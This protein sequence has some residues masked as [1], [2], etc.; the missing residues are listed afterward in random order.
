MQIDELFSWQMLSNLVIINQQNVWSATIREWTSLPLHKL[1]LGLK[2]KPD[3]NDRLH[4]TPGES[5]FLFSLANL[6]LCK[7]NPF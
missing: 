3:Y 1:T 2:N 7:H 4:C 6:I 5:H